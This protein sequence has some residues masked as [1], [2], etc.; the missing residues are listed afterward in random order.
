MYEMFVDISL[1]Q[2]DDRE[3]L[4]HLFLT[5]DHWQRIRSMLRDH[6]H[7]VDELLDGGGLMYSNAE[8]LCREFVDAPG[9]IDD[10]YDNLVREPVRQMADAWSTVHL[11]SEVLDLMAEEGAIEEMRHIERAM[12]ELCGE[13]IR[14]TCAYD[15]ERFT[16]ATSE[17]TFRDICEQHHVVLPAGG[18]F[19]GDEVADLQREASTLS[20]EVR[21]REEIERRLQE[22]VE[23]EQQLNRRKDKFLAM[24]AHELR[25][26][27]AAI[28]HAVELM[29]L[30]D[31]QPADREREIIERQMHH[32]NRLVDDLLDVS[33]V[34]RGEIELDTHPLDVATVVDQAIETA[35]P[36]IEQHDHHLRVSI[37]DDLPTVEG[38]CDR[39]SQVVS[40]LLTN[41]AQYTE[42]AGNIWLS[43]EADDD[44]VEIR[45]EDDGQGFDEE[46]RSHLFDLFY[47][48]EDDLNPDDGTLG[49]GLALAN[50]LVELHDGTLE[51]SSAGPGEGSEFVICL[52]TADREGKGASDVETDEEAEDT[53]GTRVLIVDDNRDLADTLAETLELLGHE[54]RAVYDAE[55]ALAELDEFGPDLALVDLNL[56][57]MSGYELAE[58]LTGP[59]GR[60]DLRLVALTGYSDDASRRQTGEAGFDAHLVK[61]V[62][63]DELRATMG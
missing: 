37:P 27:I 58:R 49:V 8:R 41:A 48:G 35:R 50:Q 22:A 38:D 42:P 36:T 54:V 12:A 9:S 32:M 53:T 51:A 47:R 15:L 4:V 19:G 62:G 20:S 46:T 28:L 43:V 13:D 60:R 14:G 21:Q 56:P 40:N 1:E 5:P 24:L 45:V 6:D 34:T 29:R 33:R 63:I 2:L 52:P 26:P 30:R 11:C 59:D 23:Q 31:D 17:G 44:R 61:P 55:S 3:G 25:N 18:Q 57:E 39:L 10:R 16:D 7:P